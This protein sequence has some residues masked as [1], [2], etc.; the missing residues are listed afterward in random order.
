M[1]RILQI[2]VTAAVLAAASL[3]GQ[4]AAS[5]SDYVTIGSYQS[6]PSVFFDANGAKWYGPVRYD[7][8]LYKVQAFYSY[9]WSQWLDCYSDNT[10]SFY[11]CFWR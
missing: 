4:S 1:K 6:T 5:A 9:Y 11:G 2:A 7:F 8:G 3:T 10:F